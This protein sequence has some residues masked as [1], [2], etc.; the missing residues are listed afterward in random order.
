MLKKLYLGDF[1]SS[2]QGISKVA[3]P[4][5]FPSGCM[6]KKTANLRVYS[7]LRMFGKVVGGFKAFFRIYLFPPLPP[8]SPC[9]L[10]S[11]VFFSAISRMSQRAVWMSIFYAYRRSDLVIFIPVYHWLNIIL[12]RERLCQI[13][14]KIQTCFLKRMILFNCTFYLLEKQRIGC[15]KFS[16]WWKQF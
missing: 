1:T 15:S 9:T 10:C 14:N 11:R 4:H 16:N 7:V 6:F 12:N 2:L 5:K 13:L 3:G 8:L